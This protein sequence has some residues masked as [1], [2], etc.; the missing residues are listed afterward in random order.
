M[1]SKKPED[2][3]CNHSIKNDFLP[4]LIAFSS[5]GAVSALMC[6]LAIALIVLFRMYKLLTNRIILYLLVAALSFCLATLIQMSALWQNYWK[7][8]NYQWCV[9]EGFF[10]EYSVWVMLL[11]TLVRGHFTF[12][13]YGPLCQIL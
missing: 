3:F 9:A 10:V 13:K 8:E 1:L 6:I 11:S 2:I 7:G 12:D 5:T 4:V